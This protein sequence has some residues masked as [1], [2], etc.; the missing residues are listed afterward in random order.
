MTKTESPKQLMSVNV[1]VQTPSAIHNLCES[2]DITLSNLLQVAWGVTLHRY[3][4]MD[5]VCF[6]YLVSGRDV[7]VP[8]VENIIGPFINMLVCRMDLSGDTSAV[9]LLKKNRSDFIESL[10]HQH[11]SLAEIL[12]SKHHNMPSIFNTGISMQGSVSQEY[13]SGDSLSFEPVQS[14]DP[15]EVSGVSCKALYRIVENLTASILV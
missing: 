1:H 7:P 14:H 3:T 12:S 15:T 6:G 4:G 5:E 13:E 9:N 11:L 2:H 8:G 10:R